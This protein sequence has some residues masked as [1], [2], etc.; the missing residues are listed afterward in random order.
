M[1]NDSENQLHQVEIS[2]ENAEK[3][4]EL[5]KALKRLHDNADFKTVIL[6]DFFH[7]EAHRA[8]LLKADEAMA[9]PEKQKQVDDVITTIGGLYNYFGK[10]YQMANMSAR[11]LAAHQETRE[12]ILEEQLSEGIAVQ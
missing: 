9:P 12:E 7:E 4:I 2:I 11:A 5:A 10:I 8:V 6:E 3:A 1:I